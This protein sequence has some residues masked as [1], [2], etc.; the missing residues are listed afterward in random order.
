MPAVSPPVRYQHALAYDSARGKVVLFGGYGYPPY[1]LSDTWEWDG[2][3]WNQRTPAVSPPARYDH[4]LAY[5]SARGRVVLFGGDDS[6]YAL[7]DT[8]EWDGNTWTQRTL[9]VS[10][11]AR[12]AHSLAYDSARGRVVLFG[13]WDSETWEYGPLHLA[14]YA[15][16]GS[17]CPGSAG[18]PG[19]RA[20]SG[21]LPWIAGSFR[22]DLT[23]LPTNAATSLSLGS[24][25]TAWG[26]IP[27]PFPLDPLGMTGCTLFA[28]LDLLLPVQNTGGAGSVTFAVPNSVTLVGGSLFSQAFVVDPPAN[29]AGITAS[30]AGEA[31]IGAR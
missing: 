29:A 14:S 11:P 16:F 6:R 22:I 9:A 8:W 19:L 12:S 27:L 13:G 28:S 26:P 31:R 10:P 15:P 7:S 5:D 2:S 25:R 17:G 20:A 1:L 21:Q 3:A 24:S 18:V 23:R 30:N 4:A